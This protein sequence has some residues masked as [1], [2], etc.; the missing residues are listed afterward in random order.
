MADHD[1]DV[2]TPVGY[3]TV[4]I[5]P[6]RT[7]LNYPLYLKVEEVVDDKSAV[8]QEGLFVPLND[9]YKNLDKIFKFQKLNKNTGG[10]AIYYS[11][12]RISNKVGFITPLTNNFCASCNRVRITSTG[13]LFMCLGQNDHVDFREILRNDYSND[14]IK[15]KILYA[16]KI[17]P[18]KHDFLIDEKTKPYMERHM[19]VTGG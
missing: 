16:M 18:E 5:E 8:S 3:K 10:P 9:V 13:K 12:D 6:S 15:E 17:K 2:G 19:N 4:T 1:R 11:S 7:G 14:Y